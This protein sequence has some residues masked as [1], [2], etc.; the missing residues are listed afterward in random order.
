MDNRNRRFRRYLRGIAT[1]AVALGV[2]GVAT[3]PLAGSAAAATELVLGTV[4]RAPSTSGVVLEGVFV[5][6]VADYSFGEVTVKAHMA[7]K[8]CSEM[9]CFEQ[10]SQGLMDIG[11]TTTANMEAFGSAT[12]VVNM[13]YL[14]RTVGWAERILDEWLTG[15]M[16]ER[17]EKE[18]GTRILAIHPTGGFRSLAN[19]VRTAKTPADLKGIKIRTTKSPVEGK[20]VNGWGATAVPYDWSQL[21]QGL[22]TGVV[23]GMYLPNVWTVLMKFYEVTK[24]VTE[25]GGAWTGN[26]MYMSPKK[27]AALSELGQQAVTV[28]AREME[29][30]AFGYDRRWVETTAT[31]LGKYVEVYEPTAE[32]MDLWRVPGAESWLASKGQY[33][34]KIAR[35][36]L[37]QQRLDG[38]IT[39]LEK[40]GAL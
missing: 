30:E 9:K 33:D 18:M 21:Y 27:F 6:R 16:V 24:Y 15:Y 7:G 29:R 14:F 2:A 39:A 38:F 17:A 10:T 36:I 40:V 5:P 22:Q 35:R 8:L 11:T 34:P 25:T 28:A 3:L 20:L 31:E 26:A 4:Q 23:Q 32:E 12:A 1:T 37:V 13:P 19:A